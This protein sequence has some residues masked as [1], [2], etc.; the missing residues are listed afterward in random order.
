MKPCDPLLLTN[1]TLRCGMYPT[2]KFAANLPEI[3]PFFICPINHP[4]T[5]FQK[6]NIT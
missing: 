6:M 2:G 3:S 1:G 5:S 4:T